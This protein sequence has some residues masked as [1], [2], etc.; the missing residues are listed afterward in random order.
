M[1]KVTKR[2]HN[3]WYWAIGIVIIGSVLYFS[4]A[5]WPMF[6]QGEPYAEIEAT[7]PPDMTLRVGASYRSLD[8]TT[9]TF[10][11]FSQIPGR[12]GWGEEY[13]PDSQGKVKVKIYS[14]I[15]GPCSWHLTGFGIGTTYNK[16]PANVLAV[17]SA[18]DEIKQEIVK[19]FS[20]S[21]ELTN[22]TAEFVFSLAWG[23]TSKEY[24]NANLITLNT[25]LIPSIIKR[26][27][28]DGSFYHRFAYSIE[29]QTPEGLY[30]VKNLNPYDREEPLN[31]RYSVD[32]DNRVLFEE[33]YPADGVDTSR[34]IQ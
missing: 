34:V 28:T 14:R 31:I 20:K 2:R 7:I 17:Q 22:T 32:V 21:G 4:R 24:N 27:L 26:I 8:C 5:F 25:V 9:I 23:D 15:M 16:I 6:F 1:D 13:T 12:K 33:I 3:L 19:R 29:K 30:E 11:D 10:S 18:S